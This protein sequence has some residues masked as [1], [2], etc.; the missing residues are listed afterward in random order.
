MELKITNMTHQTDN[1]GV[2]TVDWEASKSE[3]GVSH[4]V[5]GTV[6]FVPNPDKESFVPFEKL[7]EEIVLGWV[8]NYDL[9]GEKLTDIIEP[10]L[11]RCLEKL[12]APDVTNGL[13]WAA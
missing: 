11:D 12:I 3:Q 6:H 1:G 4:T 10:S 8:L 5:N 13:P 7:S 2:I 9:D